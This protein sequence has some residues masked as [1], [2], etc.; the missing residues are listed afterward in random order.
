GRLTDAKGRVVD[1]RNCV[2]IMTSNVG[3]RLIATGRKLGFEGKSEPP[4]DEALSYKRMKQ[5]VMEE[6]KKTFS[7]EFL[8]RVDDVVVF[9]A[10]NSEQIRAIV[11][12]E[13]G[14][15]KA[16][17]AERGIQLIYGDDVRELLAKEGYEPALGARPL[18]RAVRRLVED[19]LAERVLRDESEEPLRIYEMVV[20][21][22]TIV[23]KHVDA[24]V[25]L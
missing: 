6:L 4:P 9:H 13:L 18:R 11:D 22:G 25:P 20:E 15:V 3:A 8:N 17:L 12:I 24:S 21:E 5:K 10:L 2:I 7:P 23:F 16:Q 14:R 19:S 1:F